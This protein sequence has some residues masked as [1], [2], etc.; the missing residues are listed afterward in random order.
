MQKASFRS[1]VRVLSLIPT[2]VALI[3][4]LQSECNPLLRESFFLDINSKHNMP[5]NDILIYEAFL[6]KE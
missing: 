3:K 6:C 1:Y 2:P 5:I 4:H